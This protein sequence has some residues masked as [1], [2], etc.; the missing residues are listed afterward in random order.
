MAAPPAV[1]APQ[2]DVVEAPAQIDLTQVTN[3]VD[4]ALLSSSTLSE[5]QIA[6]YKGQSGLSKAAI[7]KL[8][9]MLVQRGADINTNLTEALRF[10]KEALTSADKLAAGSKLEATQLTASAED[11]RVMLEALHAA[12]GLTPP[13]MLNSLYNG[14]EQLKVQLD[15]IKGQG[16][17][18]AAAAG[19]QGVKAVSD[20]DW[21]NMPPAEKLDVLKRAVE[22]NLTRLDD[23]T[24]ARMQEA[25]IPIPQE[26]PPEETLI[27][28]EATWR[29]MP[30]AEKIRA[31]SLGLRQQRD[32]LREIQEFDAQRQTE[33][34]QEA[35][36]NPHKRPPEEI[37]AERRAA[38]I[39]DEAM[40]HPK[41]E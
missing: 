3:Q 21:N 11:E 6:F 17:E 31:I 4:T 39:M 23:I 33:G 20:E 9:T 19:P 38:Q 5:A 40:R 16:A 15:L 2:R 37:A 7:P 27:V 26:K 13:G 14:Q 41:E 1:Y 18:A 36:Q 22:G 35:R 25:G 30:P 29:E 24:K 10:Q 34:P 32:T 8:D 28:D 12:P